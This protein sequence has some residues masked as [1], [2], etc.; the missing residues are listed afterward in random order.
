MQDAYTFVVQNGGPV[1]VVIVL[2][3]VIALTITLFKL[4][5]FALRG[6]GRHKRARA[7]I[8]LWFAGERQE[9]YELVATHRSPLSRVVA[10]AMRGRTHGGA[11]LDFV[12]EDVTRV[13]LEELHELRRYLRT[14]ELIA[15]TA[16]LLGLLGTVIGMIEAF[17]QLQASGAVVNPAQLAGGIWTALISTA[18]G[19]A[20]A[21]VFSVLGA[22][23]EA[24]VEN[25]RSV[26]EITL[27]GF[28]TQR[29]TEDQLKDF[30][31]VTSLPRKGGVHAY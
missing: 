11:N 10:H 31:E 20:V 25:E 7:A 13:A 23:F 1:P 29:I 28:F 3:S 2:L 24:R 4:F 15:Q 9:G 8:E 21:I 6:V 5:Q 12:K 14:I 17:S 18:L 30:E 27:T 19:L 16:P 26:I 22:W